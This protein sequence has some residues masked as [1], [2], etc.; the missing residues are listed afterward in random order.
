[1]ARSPIKAAG[2]IVFRSGAE[3]LIAVVQLAKD[4]DWVLPKGKL[5]PGE[6]ARDAAEREVWE[7]TGYAISVHE[8]LGKLKYPTGGGKKVVHFWRMEASKKVRDP[9]SD[10]REVD[11]LPLDAALKRL[12]RTRERD[13][14]SGVGA[15]AHRARDRNGQ[16]VA[17]P[18]RRGKNG[19]AAVRDTRSAAARKNKSGSRARKERAATG[20]ARLL[21]PLRDWLSRNF[22]GRE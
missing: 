2:G 19:S 8:F 5:N 16:R 6:S 14:L 17:S 12:T 9:M 4:G 7:E 13:F 11:W 10:V 20:L 15:A 22:L 21:L 3:P 1:M 18:Q